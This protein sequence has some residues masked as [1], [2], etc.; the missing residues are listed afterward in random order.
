MLIA[1]AI[2]FVSDVG[3]QNKR[4][5]KHVINKIYVTT[6][7]DSR[8]KYGPCFFTGKFA[9]SITRRI[10]RKRQKSSTSSEITVIKQTR[11]STPRKKTKPTTAA[12]VDDATNKVLSAATSVMSSVCTQLQERNDDRRQLASSE[13]REIIAFC[14][15]VYYQLCNLD[16]D[17]LDDIEAEIQQVIRQHKRA[18]RT[19]RTGNEM[20]R[21]W[22]LMYRYD[23][24]DQCESNMS[25]TN[26]SDGCSVFSSIS[27]AYDTLQDY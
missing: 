19:Q 4:K 12:M 27:S 10:L 8:H 3:I 24:F 9:G 7:Q 23:Q 26:F 17:E 22:E 11:T 6:I 20:P 5:F 14:E 18:Q 2:H 21:G 16:G 15:M 13:N 1:T 25:N